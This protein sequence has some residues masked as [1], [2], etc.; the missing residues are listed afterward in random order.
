MPD[1]DQAARQKLICPRCGHAN[2]LGSWS[3]LNCTE[4]LP[5][6]LV[7]TTESDRPSLTTEDIGFQ[8]W[9]VWAWLGLV[10]GNLYL[11]GTLRDAIGM[12]L[13]LV[14]INSVLMVLI[15]RFNKY[16]FLIATVASINPILWIINGVYLKNRWNHPKVNR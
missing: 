3:C 4:T 15:L 14:A 6:T 12:A 10:V 7:P 9:T 16:A 5:K 8:W 11:L 13:V 2:P 1:A